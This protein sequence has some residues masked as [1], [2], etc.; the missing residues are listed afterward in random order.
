VKN[1]QP[2]TQR[3]IPFPS[4]KYVVSK[5]DLKGVITYA[6]DTFVE[7]SGFSR[8]ELVGKNH[9]IVRHPDMPPAAFQWLWD[10]IQQGLPWC[11]IVKNRAKNGDHY[12]VKAFVVPVVENGQTVGY[13]SA[14]TEPTRAEVSAAEDLYR[15]IN[16]GSVRLEKLTRT[17]FLKRLSIRARLMAVMAFMGALLAVG[18]V[19]G[20]GGIALTNQ[21]LDRTYR[22]RLE[23][24][25]MIGRISTLMADNN[26]QVALGLQHDPAH[27]IAKL[28]DH[29][30]TLHT[31]TIAKNRDEIGALIAELDKRDL[32]KDITPLLARY[33]EARKAYVGEGLAP[34]RQALLDGDFPKAN[35]ILLFSVNPHYAKA[36]A[37]AREVQDALKKAAR[38]EYAAAEKRY[39]LIRTMTIIGI[40]AALGAVAAATLNLL[41]SIVTPLRQ[42]M[43]HFDNI[44]QGDLTDEIDISGRHEAGRVLTA[45]AAMQV[46]LKVILDQVRSAALAIEARSREVRTQTDGV[47]SQSEQQRDSAQAVASAAEEFSQ[48]V[49]EVADSATSVS[50]ITESAQTEVG[51]AQDSMNNSMA[52]TRRVVSAVQES[53]QTIA[54]LDRAIAKIGSITQVIREIA[55]QTNLLALNAAIEAAR[56]GEQGRGFAVVADEVRKLAERT[57]ASTKDIASTVAE[58]RS[59]T[60][61]AVSSMD[62]AVTEVDHGNAMIEA[63]GAGLSRVT[64]V[65]KEVAVMAKHIAEAAQEQVIA[66][67]QVSNNIERIATL[68][69]GNVAASVETETVVGELLATAEE[70]RKTIN[71]FRLTK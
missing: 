15:R 55:D 71:S 10:T 21:A 69:D 19:V 31:D 44:G 11:G 29:P 61:S 18:A 59:V 38:Q 49:K 9:N 50:G 33:A 57:S 14:R 65:S 32:G 24:I 42:I 36:S 46:N 30:L 56:A 39:A 26:R 67:E 2:V 66:S 64:A 47:C 63:S 34:A 54:E 7:L 13:M 25:D 22:D 28:H 62:R 37:L 5:T 60:D 53:G 1:N 70:L 58:I 35:Q 52:A 41:G 45:L 12:W 23:P 16:A 51:K 40:L 6:N 43:R 20:I 68:I 17:P 48:S 8:E 27:P 4:G 3:E